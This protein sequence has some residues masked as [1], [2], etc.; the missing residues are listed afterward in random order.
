MPKDLYPATEGWL[1]IRATLTTREELSEEELRRAICL[2]KP[3]NYEI[4][5]L[6]QSGRT[7]RGILRTKPAAPTSQGTNQE[8]R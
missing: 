4:A 6:V 1:R 8:R 5:K 2:G 3:E 7:V